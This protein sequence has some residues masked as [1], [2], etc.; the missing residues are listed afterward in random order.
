M[1]VNQLQIFQLLLQL[2]FASLHSATRHVH[3]IY[4][5]KHISIKILPKYGLWTIKYMWNL[6]C[7]I[8]ELFSTRFKVATLDSLSSRKF[9]RSL[10]YLLAVIRDV[11]DWQCRLRSY[12]SCSLWTL[13]LF[14]NHPSA[15]LLCPLNEAAILFWSP[16]PFH[17]SVDWICLK[18]PT[19]ARNSLSTFKAVCT[20]A[21]QGPGGPTRRLCAA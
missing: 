8:F 12:F 18:P 6:F 1:R 3:A 16:V 5:S 20:V 13:F 19:K 15:A 17:Q 14:W 21:R 10:I 11:L 9:F 7:L 4:I 2:I